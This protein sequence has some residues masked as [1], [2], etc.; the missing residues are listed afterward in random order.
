MNKRL[1]QWEANSRSAFPSASNPYWRA[2]PVRRMKSSLA[3]AFFVTVV[4]GFAADLL[5]LNVQPSGRGF[6][7]PVFFGAEYH[8]IVPRLAKQ[9]TVIAVDLHEL[10]A[11]P[12]GRAATMPL[13]WRRVFVS[14]RRRSTWSTCTLSVTT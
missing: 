11:R 14:L 2:L 6:F 10:E 3:G 8:A 12:R 7:W 4:G 13:V 1:E 5:Q 9:F